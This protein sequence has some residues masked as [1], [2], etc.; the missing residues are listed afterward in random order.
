VRFEH[1]FTISIEEVT[2]A[3]FLKF[4]KKDFNRRFSATDDSPANNVSWFEAAAYCR[5]LSEQA[6][7]AEDQMCYPRA[8]EIGPGMTVPGNWRERTGYR[9][10]TEAEWEYACRGGV[11]A[12]RNCGEGETLL[13]RYAWFLKN[14]DNQAQPVGQL[15][16]NSFGIFDALGNVAERCHDEMVPYR[17]DAVTGPSTSA[18]PD[19]VVPATAERALRGGNFG[20]VDQNIRSARRYANSVQDQWALIGFRVA[21]TLPP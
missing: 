10:P 18:R 2:I 3:Q 1:S 11:S 17:A 8:S 6:G 12:S 20:D 5:W 9:L 13:P 7:L 21:R 14:S 15:K 16:P 4:R 19:L